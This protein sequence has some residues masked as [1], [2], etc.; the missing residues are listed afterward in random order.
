MDVRKSRVMRLEA[1]QRRQHRPELAHF[2][3]VVRVPHD[4]PYDDWL[5]W[6]AAQPCACQRTFCGQRRVG[7]LL[8]AK[9]DTPEAWEA[10][11]GRGLA[12]SR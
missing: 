3:S 4:I 9:C 12:G 5:V 1:R 10:R 7:A 6:L 8:P 2:T 11:Y